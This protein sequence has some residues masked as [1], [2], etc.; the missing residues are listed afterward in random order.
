MAPY[1]VIIIGAGLAGL[2]AAWEVQQ[3]GGHPIVLEARTRVGG[4][5]FTLR[6]GFHQGQYAEGGG[7]FIEVF[8]HRMLGLAR[9]FDMSLEEVPNRATEAYWLALE[10]K[11][12]AATD[13]ALWGVD[14]SSELEQPWVALAELGKAVPDPTHP[15]QA[16]SAAI[17]DRDSAANWLS[18]LKAHPLAKKAFAARLRS[19]FLLELEAYSLLDL[20]RWG[21]YYYNRPA[22]HHPAYRLVGGNDQLPKALARL[23]PDVRLN[24]PVT[25]I[26][27]TDAGVRITYRVDKVFHHLDGDYAILAIPLKPAQQ[28]EFDPPLPEAQ[29]AL[30]HDLHYGAVTK[31]LLQYRRRFWQEHEWNGNL[32]SDRPFTTIWHPTVTQTGG[33]GILTVYTGAAAGVKFSAMSEAERITTAVAEIEALFP[34]SAQWLCAART[35]A[36]SNEPYAQGGYA[37]FQ[38]GAVTTHWQTLRQPAGRVHFAGEHAADH[39]GYMEGAVESGQRA[40][41]EIMRR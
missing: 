30:I 31:V 5:V 32:L 19:E 39:Q 8:H 21:A 38:V 36:W 20:A 2:S 7:E 37:G 28:I 27:Q 1:T 35:L 34:G 6:D 18:S 40:A 33:C 12:G 23:L 4:R 9:Q 41:G 16:P 11:V 29:R 22:E 14:L 13:A 26:R 3:A 17:L 15:D 24:S 25:A 10:G